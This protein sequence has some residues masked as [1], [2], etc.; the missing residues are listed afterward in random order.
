MIKFFRKIRQRLL[1]ENKTGTY[2]KYA[3]GEIVL[4][5]VGILIALQINNW[6]ENRKVNSNQQKYLNLLKQ[7][8]L[9]N[10]SNIETELG[11][12]KL[13]IDGQREIFR[14]IDAPKDTLTEAFVNQIFFN[15]FTILVNYNYE[16]SVLTEIKNSG[17][18]KNLKN[19]SLRM[20]LMALESNFETVKIQE[21]TVNELQKKIIDH[22]GIDGDIRQILESQDFYKNLGIA[23]AKATSKGNKYAL[24]DNYFKNK[25][26]EYLGVT[27]NL[28][29]IVYPRMKKLYVDIIDKIDKEIDD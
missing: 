5:V 27:I 13:M 15:A 14:L 3:I 10:I 12:I 8:A 25:M 26:I 7:E 28:T 22:V 24:Q 17:E 2:L 1:S 20:T 11:N 4:V 6:N 21:N 16:N 19:D 29:E 23:K 18:L 9:S